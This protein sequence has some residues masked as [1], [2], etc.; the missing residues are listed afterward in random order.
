MAHRL[1]S[2]RYEQ[3][4]TLQTK[5][6]LTRRRFLQRG[7]NVVVGALALTLVGC[8]GVKGTRELS[9]RPARS[10]NKWEI[11]IMD[12]AS[13]QLDT[14]GQPA[15]FIP[16]GGQIIF[17]GS[18][19]TGTFLIYAKDSE[20][21]KRPAIKVVTASDPIA[22]KEVYY[23]FLSNGD[24]NVLYQ[25]VG[26]DRLPNKYLQITPRPETHEFKVTEFIRIN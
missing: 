3:E 6:T 23:D 5:N 18:K 16:D 9:S 20:G 11:S 1:E 25:N 19:T 4:S 24:N 14:K 10:S 7:G 26:G 13:V 15:I 22:G 8:E 17:D 2:I 21:K 12:P